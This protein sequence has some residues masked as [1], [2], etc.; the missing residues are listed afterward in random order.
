[1]Y[2]DKKII[3]KHTT[4][5]NITS[6]SK[7]LS[8]LIQAIKALGKDNISEEDIKNAYESEYANEKFIRLLRKNENAETRFV[9]GSNFVDIGYETDKRTNR[10]VVTGAI[11]NLIKGAAGQAV[12]NMNLMFG[13]DE[14]YGLKSLPMSI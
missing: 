2:R 10:I 6:Y 7:E 14:E 5:R 4:N 12:Q 9:K 1:M 11:D 8:I 13:I 3:F